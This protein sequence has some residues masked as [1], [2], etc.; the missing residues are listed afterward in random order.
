MRSKAPY[1][2]SRAHSKEEIEAKSAITFPNQVLEPRL[3]AKPTSLRATLYLHL[4]TRTTPA[5]QGR[6]FTHLQN[7]L[8]KY[9]FR[10][11]HN[12]V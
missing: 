10:K 11:K 7:S 8:R 1:F 4:R 5:A 9:S 6:F 12:F 2:G 3:L